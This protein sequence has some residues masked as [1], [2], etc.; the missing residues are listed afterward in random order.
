MTVE[1]RVVGC[2]AAAS[3]E[4]TLEEQ[5]MSL[6]V[7][8]SWAVEIA[9]CLALN[10]PCVRLSRGCSCTCFVCVF[11]CVRSRVH[12]HIP[13]FRFYFRFFVALLDRSISVF[14]E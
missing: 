8:R 3:G 4:V 6:W 2:A 12:L 10:T 11:V 13:G 1:G 7:H 9:D 5:Q 14:W